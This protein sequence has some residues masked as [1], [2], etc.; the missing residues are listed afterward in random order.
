MTL[1]EWLDAR[2]P[3]QPPEL[4][5]RIAELASRGE[6]GDIASQLLDA[7]E[8]ALRAILI[9]GSDTRESALDVLAIDALVTYAF[10]AAAQEPR[11]IPVLAADAM[12]RLS[13]ST[14][15]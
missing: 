6:G 8:R 12:T 11:R 14:G 9:T 13:H 1:Q 4:A 10:E 2:E 7:G 3:A 15:A 5:R